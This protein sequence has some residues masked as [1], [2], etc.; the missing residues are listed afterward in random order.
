MEIIARQTDT[1]VARM[2][3]SYE[4][5]AILVDK[6]YQILATNDLYREKFGLIERSR[7][8]AHCYAVSHGYDR[9]C[10]Q[11]GENCPLAAARESGQRERVLH[12]HQTP[13]G[14]EHVDVEM[15]PIFDDTGELA[16]CL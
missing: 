11:A 1:A 5:P 7:E 6:T 14:E 15:L 10:D 3:D 2:L 9:P 8:P 13:R 16:R 4:H 12:I